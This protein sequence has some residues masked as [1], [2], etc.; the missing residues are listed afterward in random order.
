MEVDIVSELR[1]PFALGQFVSCRPQ[2]SI[3]ERATEM[4]ETPEQYSQRILAYI[5]GKDAVAVQSSTP[6]K[7][8]RLIARLSPKQLRFR[9]APGK[10]SITE[11]VAHLVETELVGGYRI[12]MI[13][14]KNGAPIQ[15]FDQD[16][17]AANGNYSKQDPQKSVRLFRALR[18]F[19]L[20]L[21]RSLTQEQWNQYGMH[22]ERGKETLMRLTQ[23]F[24]GHDINHLQQIEHLAKLSR[25]SKR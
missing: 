16:V 19:N 5:D 21:L 13:L 17:W 7:I 23:M 1:E 18:E 22:E 14:S 24:A 2:Q 4:S 9:P 20:S 8:A 11:I 15:A 10:W 6:Q 3:S 25:A 12:R